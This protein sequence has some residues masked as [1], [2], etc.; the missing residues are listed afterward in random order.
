MFTCVKLNS[1]FDSEIK[2]IMLHKCL[3]KIKVITSKQCVL[4]TYSNL[5]TQHVYLGAI[6]S[7]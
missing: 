2:V 5:E 3:S 1:L 4:T 6:G 7:R